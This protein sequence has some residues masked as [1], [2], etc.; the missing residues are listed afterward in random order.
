M[1]SRIFC[2]ITVSSVSHD[3]SWIR[4]TF[5]GNAVMAYILNVCNLITVA[6]V[7]KITLLK[8]QMQC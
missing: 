2:I 8:L 3:Q 4:I 6:N 1:K 7:N 5:P